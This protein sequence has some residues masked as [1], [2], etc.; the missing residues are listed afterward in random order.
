M[1]DDDI[2]ALWDTAVAQYHTTTGIDLFA[3]ATKKAQSVDDVIKLT[4]DEEDKFKKWRNDG[5]KIAKFRSLLKASLDPLAA[6]GGV[7]AQGA[8]TVSIHD[9]CHLHL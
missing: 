7:V 4:V 2:K 8:S 1:V 6:V 3:P 9:T 5:G